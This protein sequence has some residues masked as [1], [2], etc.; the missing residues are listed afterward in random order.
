[1]GAGLLLPIGRARAEDALAWYEKVTFNGLVSTSYGINAN[2]P[3]SRSNQF[4]V[5]DQAAESFQIDVAE[6]AIQKNP[7]AA[8]EAGF[9]LHL[10]AGS[11]VPRVTASAGLFRDDQGGAQDIDIHQALACY[12]LP[13]GS[14]IRI[15]FGKHVTHLGYEVIEGY[16]GV[17]DQATRSFLFGY[18]IPFTQTGLKAGYVLGSRISAS[19]CLVNGWDNVRDNNRS[20]SVGAQL[21]VTPAGGVTVL[22]NYLGGAER[23]SSSD[24]RHVVDVVAG[25]KA[26]QRFSIG[27]NFDYGREANAMGPGEDASWTGGAVYARIAVFGP[28]SVTARGEV[29]RDTSGFRTGVPQTLAEVTLTPEFRASSGFLLRVDLRRDRSDRRVFEHHGRGELH[30][31]QTT[32]TLN[33][34]CT[35]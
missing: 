34:L 24:L 31:S 21:A 17:N 19:A 13:V 29:F 12:I 27:A 11:A 3:D 5:F 18:S 33:A 23:D 10:T 2:R 14:G 4:R 9:S 28:L 16:D 15:D 26:H 30:R 22:M 32:V 35:F 8:G 20:K 6:L 25:Y 7:V 1:V